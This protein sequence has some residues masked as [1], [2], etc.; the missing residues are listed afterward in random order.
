M[1]SLLR[2]WRY[3]INIVLLLAAIALEIFYTVCAGSCSYLRGDL[4]GLDLTYVGIGFAAVLIA[5]TL[6]KRDS[7]VLCLLAAGIGVEIVLVA[8]QVKHDV[9]CPY[10]LAFGAI[11]LLLFILNIDLQKKML[12]VISILCGFIVFSLFFNGRV[13]PTFAAERH[14]LPSSVEASP[15]VHFSV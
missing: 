5:L 7:I 10:C 14:G 2:T 13:V 1:A 4:F 15:H 11:V 12:I 9:Y 3:P 6:L 8:F